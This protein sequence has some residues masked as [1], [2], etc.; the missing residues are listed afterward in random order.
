VAGFI[1]KRG[2]RTWLVRIPLGRDASGKRLF[3]NETIKGNKKD[4]QR[5]LTLKQRELDTGTF[6]GASQQNFGAFL[7]Q[8]LDTSAKPRVRDRTFS[9]YE[10]LATR[11]LLPGL[12]HRKL[13]QIT[14]AEIQSIYASM[15]ARGLSARTVRYAHSVLHGT[16][17]QAVKWQM[18]ARNVAKLVDLP[19]QERREMRALT[20]D[21][22]ARLLAASDGTR[23][24]PFWTLLLTS[25]LRPGEALG[26]KWGDIDGDRLRVQRALV[27]Q[28]GKRW[29]LVDPKTA[30]ARRVVS[31]PTSTLRL[32]QAHRAQQLEDRLKAGAA[33]ADNDLVFATRTGEPLDYR[34]VVRRHFKPLL[35]AAGLPLMR[36]YDLRHSCATLLLAAGENV[37]VVSERLGH[38]SAALTLDVYSHVLPDMQQRAAERLESVLF[39]HSSTR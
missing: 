21:E 11:Y 38:A 25:G 9:D 8:W 6:V 31:L 16:L 30:R 18:L 20:P 12:A 33:W 14:P 36:P 34:V 15:Q 17:E 32:L 10:S 2:E 3:H 23:Y 27:R 22:A 29:Q 5:Y 13:S 1:V 4:A 26:L 37:K 28:D 19:R 24:H 39:S 7:R 35:K